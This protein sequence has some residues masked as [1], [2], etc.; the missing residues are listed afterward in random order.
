MKNYPMLCPSLL[1]ADLTNLR[2]LIKSIEGNIDMIH[3]DVMDG[4]FVPNITFGPLFVETLRKIT[5]LPLD[6][7]LMVYEPDRIIPSFIKAG[8][9]WI[10]VHH[11]AVSHL[12]RT[13]QAIRGEGAKAGVAINPS[14]PI[15]GLRDILHEC[16]YILLMSV[17]PGFGGQSY[18]KSTENRAK[19]LKK[20]LASENVDIPIE[21][22]GGIDKNK[23]I[24]LFKAGVSIFVSGYALFRGGNPKKAISEIK[25][26]LK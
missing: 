17:T 5:E 20:L 11:E 1:S 22:D 9:S 10:S 19:R 14:T 3:V 26:L 8:A 24:P 16:D 7:H 2:A 18:I 12:H 6:C 23:I 13:I 4:K 25:R 15:E 21:V